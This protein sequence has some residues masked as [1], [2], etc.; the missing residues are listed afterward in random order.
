MA[1]R[2][3]GI[4]SQ[5][6]R[7]LKEGVLPQSAVGVDAVAQCPPRPGVYDVVDATLVRRN[8]SCSCEP[9]PISVWP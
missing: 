1:K 8:P 5:S 7:W 3:A 2:L 9:Q 4:H 6:V